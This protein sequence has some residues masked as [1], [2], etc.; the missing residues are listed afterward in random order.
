MVKSLYD[1][2]TGDFVLSSGRRLHSPSDLLSV[3]TP[4]GWLS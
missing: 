1:E 2:A 3:D 4:D